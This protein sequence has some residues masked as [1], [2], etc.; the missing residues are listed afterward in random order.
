MSVNC[1]WRILLSIVLL[2][3]VFSSFSQNS[4]PLPAPTDVVL[5]FSTEGDQHNFH[6]GE[7][8]PV[9][10][11]YSAAIPGNY[12]LVMQSGK[13]RGGGGRQISC[14][15]PAEPA[16]SW[17]QP[18]PKGATFSQMLMAPCGGVGVGSGGGG[19]CGDCDGGIQLG[20]E[21]VNFPGALNVYVR[22]RTPGTYTCIASSADIT[23]APADEK[24]R[25]ALLVSS[26][27][28]A[29]NITDDPAWAHSVAI[30]YE[31]AYSKLCHSDPVP[32]GQLLQCF[33]ISQRITYL[34]TVDSLAAEVK[35]FDGRSHHWDNQFW[36]AIVRSSYPNE[37]LHL[38]TNRMQD[39]DVAAS[40]MLVEWLA[41]QDLRL[42]SPDAFETAQPVDYHAQA[43]EKLRKYVR[44]IGGSLPKKNPD[45]LQPSANTYRAFAQREYCEKGPLIPEGE[46]R[47]VLAEAGIK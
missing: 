18:A 23:T 42:E 39:P 5:R 2:A 3:L 38:M 26:N 35:F 44:L 45:V 4:D 43:V 47:E 14:S 9:K 11:S 21:P 8:I 37:A 40:T 17:R 32:E 34:D 13:L 29:L 19:E 31:D 46:Q 12:F 36:E 41:S 30:G 27:P 28:L 10:F 20:I 25:P 15:P 16:N 24:I 1:K 22:F 6:L 33:E 7:L